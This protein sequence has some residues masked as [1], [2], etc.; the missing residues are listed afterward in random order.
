MNS[1]HSLA[2]GAILI[3][4]LTAPAQQGASAPGA[5]HKN[6]HPVLGAQDAPIVDEQLKS[7]TAK[8]DL[9]ADQ[10]AKIKPILQELHD[11]QLKA[12]QDQSL[13][14]E[15]RLAMVRP[16]RLKAHDEIREILNDDQKKKFDEYLQG[17]HPEMHGKLTGATSSAQP[18]KN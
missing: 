7:L 15:E 5:T 16:Q 12:V 10:Q 1:F 14:H 11:V 8:L 9:T 17:P 18:P 4:A 13:S 6:E 3:F 2:I